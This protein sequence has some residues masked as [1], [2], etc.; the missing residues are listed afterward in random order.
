[1][2]VK[3]MNFDEDTLLNMTC[4]WGY[5]ELLWKPLDMKMLLKQLLMV[6]Q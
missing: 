2:L 3:N 5:E 4:E 6:K 1:M